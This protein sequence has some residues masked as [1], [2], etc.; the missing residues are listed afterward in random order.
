MGISGV[1]HGG[2]HP[3]GVSA[4]GT[5][6]RHQVQ[7]LTDHGPHGP[8]GPRRRRRVVLAAVGALVLV[9][10]TTAPAAGQPALLLTATSA[11]DQGTN[12][13]TAATIGETVTLRAR[14]T[15][16]ASAPLDSGS[17]RVTLPNGLAMTEQAPEVQV[18]G[19]PAPEGV[20]VTVASGSV[21]VALPA[22][23]D[24]G[25]GQEL[26]VRVTTR[27]ADVAAAVHGAVLRPSAD[28]ETTPSGGPPQRVS[29]AWRIPVV[30]PDVSV[31]LDTELLLGHI[32][33]GEVVRLDVEVDNRGSDAHDVVV[34]A[35]LDP[36]LVPLAPEGPPSDGQQ[37]ARGGGTWD[38][39][40]RSVTWRAGSDWEGAWFL[41]VEVGTEPAVRVPGAATIVHEVT[42][43]SLPGDV[44]GER[45]A[46]SG[47]SADRYAFS[48]ELQLPYPVPEPDGNDIE[49][50]QVVRPGDVV[51][52]TERFTVP[53]HVVADDVTLIDTVPDGLEYAGTQSVACIPG[54]DLEPV[55][56]APVGARAGWSLGD[57]TTP[58]DVPRT[59]VVVYRARVTEAAPTGQT[60]SF[61]PR[62]G[63]DAGIDG[64]P[65]TVP[66]DDAFAHVARDE[67]NGPPWLVVTA[68][69]VLGVRLDATTSVVE[70]GNGQD[71]ATIGEEVE[72]VARIDLP[73]ADVLHRAG[74]RLFHLGA[75]VVTGDGP[76]LTV[77]GRPAP[78]AWRVTSEPGS[79]AVDLRGRYDTREG[80]T[81]EVRL[82]ARV[83]DDASPPHGE[84]LAVRLD[85]FAEGAATLHGTDHANLTVVEPDVTVQAFL[86]TGRPRPGETTQVLVVPATRGSLAYD[87]VYSVRLDPRLRPVTEAGPVVDGGTTSDGGVWDARRRTVTWTAATL[88]TED[89]AR[90]SELDV[91]VD[92]AVHVPDELVNVASVT[93]TSMAGDVPGERT[94]ESWRGARY[95]DSSTSWAAFGTPEPTAVVV[96]PSSAAPGDEVVV[97]QVVEIPAGM[98]T[99]DVTV[100]DTLPAG[101]EHV[102]TESSRCVTPGCDLT[103]TV[104]EPDGPRLGWFV[105]D[106]TGP[107]PTTRQV[108]VR[109]R[110]RVAE[111]APGGVLRLRP[112]VGVNG[113]DRVDVPGS[114][115]AEDTFEEAVGVRRAA[116]EP[117]VLVTAPAG[118]PVPGLSATSAVVEAG[119]GATDVTI[120]EAA[121]ISARV[122]LPGST[123][124]TDGRVRVTLPAG[125]EIVEVRGSAPGWGTSVAGRDVVA[126]F[127]EGWSTTPD[128]VLDLHVD[129]RVPDRAS[130]VHGGRL[131]ARVDARAQWPGGELSLR[132]EAGLT[133]VEPRLGVTLTQVDDGRG[134]ST[135]RWE[136]STGG[137]P[138]YDV[139]VD[140]R[141]DRRLRP[142]AADGRPAADQEVLPSGGLWDADANSVTFTD[143][144][145]APGAPRTGTVDVMITGELVDWPIAAVVEAAGASLPG[146]AGR[147]AGSPNGRGRYT[148]TAEVV[149]PDPGPT[150]TADGTVWWDGDGDGVRDRGEAPLREVRVDV[151]GAGP[152]GVDGTADDVATSATTGQRGEWAVPGLPRGTVQV[153][154]GGLPGGMVAT[155]D[156]D[157]TGTPGTASVV[158]AGGA[159][160]QGLDF[161]FTGTASVRGTV[162]VDGDGDR[163]RDGGEPGAR[164][165]R[166]IVMHLGADGRPGG[167]DD[168]AVLVGTVGDGSFE[169]GRLLAGAY[170]VVVDPATFPQGTV[171]WTD[172]DGGLPTYTSVTLAPRERR[173]GVDFGL[174][175]SPGYLGPR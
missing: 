104:L 168:V 134:R 117:S 46:T 95:R 140:L 35:V 54:C 89:F 22:G 97:T 26:V 133:V 106:V 91:L 141:L 101:L 28:V 120:G 24:T 78:P 16:P 80:R 57:V 85:G 92:P 153:T 105:G 70:P 170:A 113:V 131:V 67:W 116:E 163:V 31:S 93:A 172:V 129:V 36:Q 18:D 152:D 122:V 68:G 81:L 10:A 39:D 151:T 88:Q 127:S 99:F 86:G 159:E 32:S 12:G 34:R 114:A 94:A 27:V 9:G 42:A 13:A 146:G 128:G 17:V 2:A 137:S 167:A 48:G 147:D 154:V 96:E 77:D 23:H 44:E 82:T 56:L 74:L 90:A 136:T 72:L 166:V 150:Q 14:V 138:A 144:R 43:T 125:L 50:D 25:A 66:P 79:V 100:L 4:V 33:P 41:E 110:V 165:V 155:A 1:P 135:L 84:V 164:G 130:V 11:I 139:T 145:L 15:L 149:V 121:T 5:D 69:P 102:R 111:D 20:S 158:L 40:T 109:Y 63:V 132:E 156:P 126:E 59:V 171:A 62:V 64:I 76:V 3:Q 49:H 6:G 71:Q 21:V 87:A 7:V 142:L 8:R 107:S 98:S 83:A 47:V 157:G 53:R 55:E 143:G 174:G 51:T 169:A 29:G 30:E 160:G 37:L 173:T 58:S 19:G 161:G 65:G 45:T 115:P 118:T 61:D 52:V 175:A 112:R 123:P 38:E 75:L 108:E 119:N 148:A 162:W 73:E 103:V 60:L 124:L